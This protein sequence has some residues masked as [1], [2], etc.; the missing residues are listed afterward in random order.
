MNDVKKIIE[1]LTRAKSN[2]VDWASGRCFGYVYDPGE[3]GL[4]L[5]KEAF[6]MYLSDTVLD[7]KAFPSVKFLESFV[8]RFALDLLKA[9]KGSGSV[10]TTGGTESIFL[11]VL[12][13]REWAK[14]EKGIVQP[15]IVIPD[16]IHPAF[17]KACFYLGVRPIVVAAG[18][19]YKADTK[20]IEYYINENTIMLAGSAP[21]YGVGQIDSLRELGRIAQE[22]GIGMVVDACV[23]GGVIPFI[24]VEE[25]SFNIPGVTA[26]TLDWHKWFMS[27]KGSSSVVYR[28][29]KMISYQ[30]FSHSAWMGYSIVNPTITSTRSAGHLASTYAILEYFGVEGYRAV[31]SEIM[32]ASE[33]IKSYVRSSNILKLVG[34][35]LTNVFAFTSSSEVNI[36][37]LQERLQEKGWFIQP[38]VGFGDMPASCHISVNKGNVSAVDDFINILDQVLAE[39]GLN[40]ES[41]MDK[42]NSLP[43][44]KRD[45]LLMNARLGV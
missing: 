39:D 12:A 45:L 27:V 31:A 19:D 16:T 14:S 43:I 11:S 25:L 42:I 22:S 5:V 21:S 8:D 2:D 33:K 6:S 23:G 40:A 34:D 17:N 26:I 44:R 13:H 30:C 38:Q 9:P 7:T 18:P 32:E 28:D 1:D 15:N 37:R 36:F 35:P 4:S 20:K 41:P 29:K 10:F 3:E 24:D